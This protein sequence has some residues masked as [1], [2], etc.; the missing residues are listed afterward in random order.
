MPPAWGGG[1][2]H[3]KRAAGWRLV[4]PPCG[5]LSEVRGIE[6]WTGCRLRYGVGLWALGMPSRSVDGWTGGGAP[7]QDRSWWPGSGHPTARSR[8]TE[9]ARLPSSTTILVGTQRKIMDDVP[10]QTDTGQLWIMFCSGSAQLR[11]FG[12]CVGGVSALF[13]RRGR[14]RCQQRNARMWTKT[15][16]DHGPNRTGGASTPRSGRGGPADQTLAGSLSSRWKSA[17]VVGSGSALYS[18]ARMRRQIW[19]C[20][21]AWARSPIRV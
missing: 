3:P 1:R 20:R 7:R 17:S 21:S 13:R 10:S 12:R 15:M 8:G 2:P 18:S 19:Y 6:A 5:G 16:L 4:I 9:Q 11:S 14:E